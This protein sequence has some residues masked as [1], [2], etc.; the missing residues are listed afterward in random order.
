[1]SVVGIRFQD[2]ALISSCGVNPVDMQ[3]Q[4]LC[5]SVARLYTKQI[6]TRPRCRRIFFSVVICQNL[7][8]GFR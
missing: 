1:M 7:Q 2:R 8:T 4:L 3:I 6:N 5:R